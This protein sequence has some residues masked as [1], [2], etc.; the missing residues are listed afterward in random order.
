MQIQQLLVF[1]AVPRHM[2]KVFTTWI[3]CSVYLQLRSAR[4]TTKRATRTSW[5]LNTVNKKD[6]HHA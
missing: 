4:L 3:M 2:D 5:E 1:R 6:D